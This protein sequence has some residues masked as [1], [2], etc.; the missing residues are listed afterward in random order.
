M[1]D[2]VQA[3]VEA[4]NAR[5]V[6]AFVACY[7]DDVVIS[8]GSATV[9]MTGRAQLRA[10]YGP[11]FDAHPDL[12]AEIVHRISA[13]GWTVDHERVT[14]E[15]RQLEVL[16]AYQVAAGVIQRVVMLR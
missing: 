10:A 14:R 11:M 8:D 13:G 2:P 6:E 15:G 16:V 12:R 3:Q 5:D 1:D 7:A 4:Y 9:L